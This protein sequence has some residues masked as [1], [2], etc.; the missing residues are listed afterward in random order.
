MDLE[1]IEPRHEWLHTHTFEYHKEIYQWDLL[2]FVRH[3]K[4]RLRQ[5]VVE[6]LE[7]ELMTL[8]ENLEYSFLVERS[9]LPQIIALNLSI[10]Q[11]ERLIALLKRHKGGYC[12]EDCLYHGNQSYILYL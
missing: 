12:L 1:L 4:N 9:K 7:L 6:P 5:S 3:K 2:N 8:L 11:E 10:K